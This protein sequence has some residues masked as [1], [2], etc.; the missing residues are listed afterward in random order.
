MGMDRRSFF[1]SVGA[2]AATALI[3][4]VGRDSPLRVGGNSFAA[5]LQKLRQFAIPPD[6]EPSV[7][8]HPL[9]RNKK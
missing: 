5:E 7:T 6:L 2:L 8:F 3:G 9:R 4:C 1:T